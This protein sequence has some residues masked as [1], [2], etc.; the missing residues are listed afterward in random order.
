[1]RIYIFFLDLDHVKTYYFL[2]IAKGPHA[3][4]EK[5]LTVA[6]YALKC[7]MPQFF[8]YVTTACHNGVEI[9]KKDHMGTY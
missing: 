6:D 3:K 5:K 9:G 8:F 2:A 7:G 1:M 4:R